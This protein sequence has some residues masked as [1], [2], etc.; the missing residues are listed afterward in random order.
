MATTGRESGG[1][2]LDD[3]ELCFRRTESVMDYNVIYGL[4]GYDVS[5]VFM[6]SWSEGF[7]RGRGERMTSPTMVQVE[8]RWK[9]DSRMD[10]LKAL[11][12][13]RTALGR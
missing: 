8:T 6:T 9:S 7:N 3:V 11:P 2:V 13:I 1:V 5:L 12:V 10:S 4:Q